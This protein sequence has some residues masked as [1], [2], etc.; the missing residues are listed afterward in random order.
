[1]GWVDVAPLGCQACNSH[2]ISGRALRAGSSSK[3]P[4]LGVE[5]GLDVEHQLCY[6][7]VW[8]GHLPHGE[9]SCAPLMGLM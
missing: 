8:P 2:P 7:H 1:M 3:A 5:G 6:C 9:T 4:G